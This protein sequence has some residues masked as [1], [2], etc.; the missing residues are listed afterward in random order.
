[1]FILRI[2]AHQKQQNILKLYLFY[3]TMSCHYEL[4]FP[5][6]R[7]DIHK[8]AKNN[9]NGMHLDKLRNVTKTKQFCTHAGTPMHP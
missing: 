9:S 4:T 3:V 7:K 1:M 6:L 5:A 8:W 2:G